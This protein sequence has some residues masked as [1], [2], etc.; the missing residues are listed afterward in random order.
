MF[1][2][3]SMHMHDISDAHRFVYFTYIPELQRGMVHVAKCL[4]I[5]LFDCFPE[6]VDG[7]RS[8]DLHRKDRT[9]VDGS[10]YH[11]AP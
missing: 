4:L 9:R 1:T 2:Y 10:S 11:P 5:G 7:L 8:L 6:I 3:Q